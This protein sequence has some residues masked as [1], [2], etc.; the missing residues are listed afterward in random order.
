MTKPNQTAE[1]LTIFQSFAKHYPV[2][3]TEVESRNPPEPD[4]RC[5]DSDGVVLAFELVELI[6][7]EYARKLSAMF[8]LTTEF[9]QSFKSLSGDQHHV[10][11]SIF[12]EFHI[13][14]CCSFRRL[15]RRGNS[16]AEEVSHS[17]GLHVSG[18]TQPNRFR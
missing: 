18:I 5:K 4:I 13:K 9:Q 8:T 12:S 7:Q 2:E 14:E 17:E 16:T 1:E 6:D 11:N 15:R 3:V 10:L